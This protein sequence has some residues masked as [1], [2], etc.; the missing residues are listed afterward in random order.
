[1]TARP[2]KILD[3]ALHLARYRVARGITRTDSDA[4]EVVQDVFLTLARKIHG[5]EGRAPRH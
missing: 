4:E 2:S 1:V 5:F 3:G